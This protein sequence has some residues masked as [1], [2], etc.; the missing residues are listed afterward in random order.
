MCSKGYAMHCN[1]A[2]T[3]RMI[4]ASYL[5]RAILQISFNIYTHIKI[6]IY[7]LLTPSSSSFGPHQLMYAFMVWFT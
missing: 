6:I 3:T 7:S 5:G 2:S 4:L 1:A